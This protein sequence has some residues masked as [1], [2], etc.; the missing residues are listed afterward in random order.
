MLSVTGVTGPRMLCG[1]GRAVVRIASFPWLSRT[2]STSIPTATGTERTSRKSQGD[3]TRWRTGIA[4]GPAASGGLS[5]RDRAP[6]PTNSRCSAAGWEKRVMKKRDILGPHT[7]ETETR[8]AEHL[9]SSNPHSSTCD[10][11]LRRRRHRRSQPSRSDLEMGSKSDDGCARRWA[12]GMHSH[13][14]RGN[15]RKESKNLPCR[16]QASMPKPSCR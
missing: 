7:S 5:L 10:E 13:E 15:A 11:L 6:C 1:G 3:A 16:E 4:A 12:D 8:A 14:R 9:A 2:C